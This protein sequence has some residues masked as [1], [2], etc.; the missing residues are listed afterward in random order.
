MSP[1]T[2]FAVASLTAFGCMW[3]CLTTV[4]NAGSWTP[5]KPVASKSR[6]LTGFSADVGDNGYAAMAYVV[7]G[8]SLPGQFEGAVFVKVRRP[9]EKF[10][11]PAIFRGVTHTAYTDV[12]IGPGGMTLLGY[13][14]E[15]GSWRVATRWPWGDWLPTQEVAGSSGIPRVELSIGT[16][17]NAAILGIDADLAAVKVALRDPLSGLFSDWLTVSEPADEPG[18]YASIAPDR[19]GEWMVVWSSGCDPETGSG[20]ILWREIGGDEPAPALPVSGAGCAARGLDLQADRAG[21]MFLRIGLDQGVQVASRRIGQQFGT[22][23]TVSGIGYGTDGGRLSVS[24]NGEAT[25]VWARTPE[26]SNNRDAYLFVRIKA[27]AEPGEAREITGLRLGRNSRNDSLRGVSPLPHGGLALVFTRSWF[28][29][30]GLV[31]M[32]VGVSKWDRGS[33]PGHRTWTKAGPAGRFVN[34]IGI[35]TSFRGAMLTWWSTQTELTAEPLGY[36][37]RARF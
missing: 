17:G 37:W 11:R 35:E 8:E 27:G 10:F 36:W 14:G 29:R 22:A 26:G 23:S 3:A 25:L 9:G 7:P 12:E 30:E 15:N 5:T 6:Q 4:A 31:R 16:E 32:K 13:R 19:Y 2:R 20:K 1:R 34:R 28:S 33:R 18:S 21:N 24:G